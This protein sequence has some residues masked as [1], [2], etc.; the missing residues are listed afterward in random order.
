MAESLQQMLDCAVHSRLV[1]KSE[2]EETKVDGN[3][4]EI[5][6]PQE[7]FHTHKIVFNW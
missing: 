4:Q 6:R 5:L 1:Y 3:I 7:N 2:D